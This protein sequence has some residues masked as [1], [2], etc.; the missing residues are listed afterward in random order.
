MKTRCKMQCNTV[1]HDS[2]GTQWDFAVVYHND[3]PEHENSKFNEASPSG[4]FKMYVDK[5]VYKGKH[6]TPGKEYYFDIAECDDQP[7]SA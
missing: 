4:D 7:A 6:P 5:K 3:D 2:N 1:T